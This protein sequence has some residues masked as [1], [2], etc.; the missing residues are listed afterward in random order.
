MAEV[1]TIVDKI[2]EAL[3][4]QYCWSYLVCVVVSPFFLTACK[5]CK[6]F[7]V[8]SLLYH[9][10]SYQSVCYFVLIICTQ[11]CTDITTSHCYICYY[12]SFLLDKIIFIWCGFQNQVIIIKSFTEIIEPLGEVQD[13][14]PIQ[15]HC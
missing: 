3:G 6:T 14:T 2:Y 10:L 8:V 1:A 13:V 4:I 5:V 12:M 11:N 7:K 9:F 15:Q